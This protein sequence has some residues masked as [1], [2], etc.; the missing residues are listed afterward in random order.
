MSEMLPAWTKRDIDNT[1][2]KCILWTLKLLQ[3]ENSLRKLKIRAIFQ[4][5]RSIKSPKG[6][7]KSHG[8]L[9]PRLESNQGIAT[10][11]PDQFQNCCGSDTS[12][13]LSFPSILNGKIYRCAIEHFCEPFQEKFADP[14]SR[15]LEKGLD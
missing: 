5:K 6:R 11:S 9:F 7:A 4:G 2:S 3:G 12:L 1:K 15:A 14:W 13:S 8:I 10:I